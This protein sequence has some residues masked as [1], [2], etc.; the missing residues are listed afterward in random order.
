MWSELD[1]QLCYFSTPHLITAPSDNT[2]GMVSPSQAISLETENAKLCAASKELRDTDKQVQ[3]INT[4]S[5]DVKSHQALLKSLK[6][7]VTWNIP[8]GRVKKRHY[9]C[10]ECE[11]EVTCMQGV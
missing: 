7:C 5:A 10:R 3:L 4:L 9:A 6:V 11:G 2:H 1:R 8:T